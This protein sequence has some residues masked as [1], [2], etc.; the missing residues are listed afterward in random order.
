MRFKLYSLLLITAGLFFTVSCDQD[1][2][3][4]PQGE[5]RIT[6]SLSDGIVNEAGR[7]NASDIHSILVS[8]KDNS[9]NLVYEK[10]KI[11]LFQ[12][13]AGY[14]SEAIALKPGAYTLTEFLVVNDNNQVTYAT[15]LENSDLAHLV[16]DPLPKSFSIT[17]D[18]VTTIATEVI[19]VD[20]SNANSFGYASFSLGIIDTF[21]FLTGVFAFDQQAGALKLVTSNI[22]IKSGNTVLLSRS[23]AAVTNQIYLKQGLGSYTVTISKSGYVSYSRTFTE[24][25]LKAYSADVLIVTLYSTGV[26]NGL[27]VYYPFSGNANDASGNNLHG[28]VIGATLAADHNNNPNS[29]YR[30]DGVD[31]HINLGNIL[32]EMQL[33]FTISAWVK[34]ENTSYM[35]PIFSSQDNLPLYNGITFQVAPHNVAVGYGDGFGENHPAYRRG[36]TTTSL[37]DYTNTWIHVCGVVKNK[38]EMHMYVNGVD[39]GGYI[40]GDSMNPMNSNFPDDVARIGRWTSN[41]GTYFFKGWID[42]LKVWDRALAPSEVAESM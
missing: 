17:K 6:F 11:T 14:L 30:F 31:D 36:M 20:A 26:M 42:E 22:E 37:P 5:G 10:H 28:T 32:D 39:I 3:A 27:K 40:D 21:S 24:A 33:P 9:G 4:D 18:A 34:M 8:V 12:M 13:G 38:D 29:A 35:H 25:E 23:M 16:N 1:D 2:A 19:K 7:I 41:G 15:P